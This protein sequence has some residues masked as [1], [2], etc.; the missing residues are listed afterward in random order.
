MEQAKPTAEIA[1]LPASA[2]ASHEKCQP[3]GARAA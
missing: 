1:R 3:G 2:Q